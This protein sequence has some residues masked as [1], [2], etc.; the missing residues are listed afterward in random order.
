MKVPKE[1]TSGAGST[2]GCLVT[3]S[4]RAC[5]KPACWTL[6]R[7][8]LFFPNSFCDYC[9][10]KYPHFSTK[11]MV[12]PSLAQMWSSKLNPTV[13]STGKKQV[14]VQKVLHCFITMAA[15][16]KQDWKME[17]VQA[18]VSRIQPRIALKLQLVTKRHIQSGNSITSAGN[19]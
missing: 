8:R 10:N 4:E 9:S 15:D 19:N 1:V 18:K 2:E 3:S 12:L 14:E 17:L 6:S 13:S 11:Q 7:N 5:S 16:G